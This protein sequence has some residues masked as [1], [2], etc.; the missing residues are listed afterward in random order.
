MGTSFGKIQGLDFNDY[1]QAKCLMDSLCC[2][3]YANIIISVLQSRKLRLRFSDL[4][5]DKQNTNT[6]VVINQ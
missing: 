6:S 5:R 3:F 4:S 1:L 2:L